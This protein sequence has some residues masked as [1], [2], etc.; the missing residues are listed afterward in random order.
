MPTD[1]DPSRSLAACLRCRRQ[2]LKCGGPG[3]IPC[4]RCRRS[5]A[6]CVFVAPKASQARAVIPET[7]KVALLEQ[8]LDCV[9]EQLR[10]EIQELQR[11]V[12][13]LSVPKEAAEGDE[14]GPSRSESL[15]TESHAG[16]IAPSTHLAQKPA[17]SFTQSPDYTNDIVSSGI[18]TEDEWLQLHTFF[19]TSCRNVIAILDDQIYPSPNVLRRHSL[20]STVICT[21]AARA[22]KPERY[23]FFLAKVDNL[24]KNTFDGPVPDLLDLWAMMLLAAWTGRTRLWGYIAS[25]AGEM[26]LNEAALHCGNNGK[27]QTEET[28]ER[29]R[30]WFTLCCFDLLNNLT[31]PF[32]INK[33][34][35]YLAC[36]KKLLDSPYCRPVDFRICTYSEGFAIAGDVKS[37]LK[38][39]QL[40]TRPLQKGT[41]DLLSSF[42]AKVDAWFHAINNSTNPLYQT[43]PEVQDRNRFMVPYAFL[44]LYINGLALHSI[45]SAADLGQDSTRIAFICT[46]LDN[47]SLLIQT[48]FESEAFRRDFRYT[49]SYNGTT[50]FHASSFILKAIAV[51]YQHI[52]CQKYLTRL[53]QAA[54]LFDLA[55]AVEL[56]NDLRRGRE[57]L[58]DITETILTPDMG[59]DVAPEDVLNSALFDIPTFLDG[60]AWESDFPSLDMFIFD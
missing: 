33:M 56:A 7:D 8:R 4:Q 37:R 50:T 49:I 51:A 47:A 34:K 20:M 14:L 26:K 3:R 16:E 38:S 30:T 23:K 17:E 57:K 45:E 5:K 21:I 9:E 35:D 36:A 40:Q 31:T 25:I 55:G 32:V 52:D 59:L 42:D 46:A 15:R 60:A 53:R 1:I 27:G 18:T 54:Q 6:E 19:L 48:Q 44:K 2:K 11:T 58:G 41:V 22:I 24:I 13:H 10:A 39:S 28:V 29:A 12:E 43:F